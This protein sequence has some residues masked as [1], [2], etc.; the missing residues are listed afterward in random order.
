MAPRITEALKPELASTISACKS[1]SVHHTAM[2]RRQLSCGSH[3][4]S[5]ATSI[6][7]ISRLLR[8]KCLWLCTSKILVIFL[9]VLSIIYQHHFIHRFFHEVAK[10]VYQHASTI[11]REQVRGYFRHIILHLYDYLTFKPLWAQGQIFAQYLVRLYILIKCTSSNPFG[12]RNEAINVV[13]ESF[14]F[15]DFA[16][17]NET[18]FANCTW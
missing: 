3:I 12:R 5:R 1:C 18:N 13:N 9:F 17:E 6:P 16:L 15:L 7:T 8:G 2:L 14:I 11:P 4:S 10:L